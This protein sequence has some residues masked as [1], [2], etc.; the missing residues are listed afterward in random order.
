MPATRLVWSMIQ[1][2]YPPLLGNLTVLKKAIGTKIPRR[3]RVLPPVA[4]PSS[5]IMK[6]LSCSRTSR[7]T[8][9]SGEQEARSLKSG[10]RS[11]RSALAW[12]ARSM[13]C[14]PMLASAQP[15]H[16]VASIQCGGFFPARPCMS[17]SPAIRQASRRFLQARRHD[18][19]WASC[20]PSSNCATGNL[21]N[22]PAMTSTGSAN[23]R[24]VLRMPSSSENHCPRFKQADCAPALTKK[25]V[26]ATA[27]G[28]RR[29]S[30]SGAQWP[31]SS[32]KY[33]CHTPLTSWSRRYSSGSF[34][35]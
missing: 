11:S 17:H 6:R 34:E 3:G 26:E 4:M 13:H 20:I 22:G 14:R 24:A 25:Y 9:R 18:A 31:R 1:Q 27:T 15:S 10:N 33:S 12:E 16:Q 32:P 29:K 28:S 8:R 7:S 35:W 30:A 21:R 2:Q 23:A 5:V 19:R